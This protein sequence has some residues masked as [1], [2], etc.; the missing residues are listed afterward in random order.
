MGQN[1]H[2]KYIG[3]EQMVFQC[4]GQNIHQKYIGNK[5]M[6]FQCMS[7]VYSHDAT[8]QCTSQY[9]LYLLGY[10]QYVGKDSLAATYNSFTSITGFSPTC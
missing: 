2:Q 9:I 3:N 8:G 5:Q 7:L 10:V 6:S 1:I 4:M